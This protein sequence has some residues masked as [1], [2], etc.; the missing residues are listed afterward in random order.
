MAGAP[1][2]NTN[3]K[4]KSIFQQAVKRALARKGGNVEG[5]LNKVA[6]KLIESALN[7]EQWAIKEIADRLDGKAAQAV[8]VGGDPD[9]PLNLIV[10]EV[11]LRPLSNDTES[12]D[13]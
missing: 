6:D 5:G 10:N 7:G 3:A 13:S 12:S 2:G 9:N 1:L 4:N 11:L 8:S